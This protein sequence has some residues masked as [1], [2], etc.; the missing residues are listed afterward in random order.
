MRGG[1]CDIDQHKLCEAKGY[2]ECACHCHDFEPIVCPDV[3][4]ALFGFSLREDGQI[5]LL[6]EDDG[7]WHPVD[8]FD[9]AWLDDLSRVACEAAAKFRKSSHI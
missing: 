4:G 3:H 8:S 5:V 6:S 7:L 9:P 1:M 2:I